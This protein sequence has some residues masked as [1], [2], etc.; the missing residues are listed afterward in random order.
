MICLGFSNSCLE[1]IWFMYKYKK[2]LIV[3]FLL[4][5]FLV[6][7]P[8]GAA[9]QSRNYVIYENVNHSFDGPVISNVAHSVSGR[10]VTVTWDTNVV[11]DAFVVYDTAA[12]LSSAREQGSSAK[13]STSHSV[14]LT[15]LAANTTYYYKVRSERVNGGVTTSA[16]TRQFTTGSDEPAEG[17]EEEEEDP[18]GG[19]VLIIDKSDKV[20]P[21]ITD[22]STSRVSAEAVEVTW[23]TNEESTS[24]VEYGLTGEYGNTYGHWGTST[25]H[26][27]TLRRLEPSTEYH[28]RVLSSDSWGNIGR[29]GDNTFTTGIPGEEPPEEEEGV[30]PTLPE[31]EDLAARAREQALAFLSRLFPAVSL[32]QLDP[33]DLDDITSREDLNRFIPAPILSGEPSLE[34]GADQATVRWT[35]DVES[36]SQVA[37]ASESAYT[38][39]ADEPYQQIVGNTENLV[40]EH[41]VTLY[42][43]QPNTTYHYQLR[44]KAD[45]GPVATS[46]DFTFTT[47][48]ETLEITS[49]YSQVVDRNT[50]SFRWVTNQ[51]AT[52]EVTLTPYHGDT[53]AVDE[54]KTVRDTT[55][56]TIHEME[57]SEFKEGMFY[58]VQL[59]ST[60]NNGNTVREELDRFATQEDDLPPEIL[61][62]KADSTVYTDN[63]D[64][65]QTIIS[66]MTNEPTTSRVLYQKGVHGSSVE[67]EESTDL[68][69]NYTKEHVSV[70]TKFEPGTVYTFRVE[71]IDSGGNRQVSKP[72]TFMTA[73]KKESI[74]QVILKV[75]ENTFGWLKKLA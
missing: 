63:S 33:G 20:A 7:A 22:V 45:L 4:A 26:T 73:K 24:F 53:L 51:E 64:K 40:T 5:A 2:N 56:T 49:F 30:E 32:N 70:I 23:Q 3:L 18:G 43:L 69:D 1:F 74:I 13:N 34:V 54:S 50:A 46:R 27:V 71:S 62:V 57:I 58:N 42:E 65:I 75:L 44:S 29:S 6:P 16:T 66:W 72:H 21:E 14:D 10:S 59:A 9:M 35:T 48:S 19:G 41:E 38:P 28:F 55:M 60:G 17:E 67:L 25:R 31:D 47:G 12:G 61:H 52:S 11:A 37:M 15:G 68:N 8:L 39:E 36:T